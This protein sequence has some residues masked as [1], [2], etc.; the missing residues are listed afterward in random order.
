ML[1]SS[2]LVLPHTRESSSSS[3]G[4]FTTRFFF[5]PYVKISIFNV[6]MLVNMRNNEV[7]STLFSLSSLTF[8][9]DMNSPAS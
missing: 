7:I 3:R 6:R 9:P 4:P 2:L 5:L 8:E 1:T